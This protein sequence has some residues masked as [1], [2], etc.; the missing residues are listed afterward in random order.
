MCTYITY[1]TFFYFLFLFFSNGLCYTWQVTITTRQ[2]WYGP[3]N[4]LQ[5]TIAHIWFSMEK[6]HIHLFPRLPSSTDTSIKICLLAAF[7]AHQQFLEW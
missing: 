7:M 1:I 3:Y 6:S 4:A 5:I 2:K